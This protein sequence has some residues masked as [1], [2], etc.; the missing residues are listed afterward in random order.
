M[1]YLYLGIIAAL[2]FTVG[3]VSGPFV[4]RMTQPQVPA[5]DVVQVDM[6][7]RGETISD[8]SLL[9]LKEAQERVPGLIKVP[10]NSAISSY[11]TFC[12]VNS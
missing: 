4:V 8:M 12:Y 7:P 5:E 2:L 6:R 9:G 10:S 1:R 3:V 11:H